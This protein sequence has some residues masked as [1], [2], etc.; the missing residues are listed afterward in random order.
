MCLFTGGIAPILSSSPY[1]LYINLFKR[2]KERN[3]RYYET[4]PEDTLHVKKIIRYLDNNYVKLPS[5]GILT[6]R[7]FLQLGLGLGGTPIYNFASLHSLIN[8]AF[9]NNNEDEHELILLK[10]F[11]KD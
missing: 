2:V 5:G 4:H 9:L 11:I 3:I 1:T 8:S 7:R 6:P 10:G